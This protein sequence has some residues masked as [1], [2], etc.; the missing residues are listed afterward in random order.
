MKNIVATFAFILLAGSIGLN[1]IQY[2][3]SS[4]SSFLLK[5]ETQRSKILEDEIGELMFSLQE[6]TTKAEMG[7]FEGFNEGVT[8]VIKNVN[9]E[10]NKW[11]QLWHSGYYR[12]LEQQAVVSDMHFERGFEEGYQKGQREN[13]RAIQTIIKSGNDIQTAM[14]KFADD[15]VSKEKAA[16]DSKEQ[17]GFKKDNK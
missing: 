15:I 7:R 11:S 4:K 13:M 10:E 8:S 6:K 9:P 12:G 1:L 14:Q 2:Q 17:A 16:N 5:I 3:D